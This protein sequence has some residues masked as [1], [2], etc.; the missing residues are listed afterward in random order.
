MG[1]SIKKSAIILCVISTIIV[2]ATCGLVYLGTMTS[3]ACL[4][5]GRKIATTEEEQG[6]FSSSYNEARVKFLDAARKA[7]G[8]V[9][10]IEH[11][12]VGPDG[13]PLFIDMAYFGEVDN[14][15]ALVVISG[16][17]GVEGFA[18]SGIQ[19]GLLKHGFISRLPR[20]LNLIMI[21][22][23]NPYG[24]AHL[25]RFTEENVDLNRNFR[26]HAQPA[27]RNFHYETLAN[28]IAP[29][30]L[31]FWSEVNSWWQILW[32]RLTEG[33]VAAQ[34]AVSKGQ[35][36]H[37]TGL[38][39]GGR[40]DTWSNKMIRSIVQR[41]LRDASRVIVVD[42]HTGLG[43]YGNAELI[44]NTPANSPE[45]Q[46]AVD[47]WSK[48]LVKTTVT[49]DSV[50]V[51]LDAPLKIAIPKMLPNT[52]VTAVSLEFG[53]VPPMVVF[54]ALRAE[55]WLHHHGGSGYAKANEIKA[56]LLRAFYP[57]DKEWKTSVWEKGKDIV[58]R[59]AASLNSG[60]K[61]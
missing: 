18:G 13:Q 48:T 7:G 8:S 40:D 37:P 47:I 33:K 42:V 58:E 3:R 32:F 34:A 22:A 29:E 11:P 36:T 46:R 14:T 4:D 38:F 55:N 15:S 30:S 50:S 52:E 21:H 43:K 16:T 1:L 24:M 25:R 12:E 10:S 20:D 28:A 59:A 5:R 60:Q 2:L 35:Y 6:Y 19:T 31:S 56:C 49:G 44:L 61:P 54:K 51:H 23:L 17:H 26:D 9:Y 53:T 39:Y 27:L 57:D 45:Y 41:H